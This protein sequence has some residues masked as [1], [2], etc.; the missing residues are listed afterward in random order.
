MQK[1]KNIIFDLGGVIV[2]LDP[3]RCIRVFRELNMP[4]IA[5]LINPY[6][7]AAMLGE[8]EHGDITFHQMCDKMRAIA[9]REEVSDEQ[10]AD[11]Y[12]HF[13]TGIEPWKLTMLDDLRQKGYKLY[14]LSNNNPMSMQTVRQ[15]FTA[16]GKTMD[17]YFDGIYLS[18]QMRSL[19]PSEEI[20]RKMI[21]QSGMR[22]EESLFID[23]SLTNVHVAQGLGF[24]VYQPQ[25]GEDF[26]LLFDQL[27]WELE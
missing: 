5:E 20:Y 27:D 23:D 22:P 26:R 24:A 9:Q 13:L 7:P 4:E 21:E 2:G 6:H 3:E 1:I 18:Y 19:K 8:L 10:I 12:N 11:A 25:D 14:A 16:Q 17:D 15:M